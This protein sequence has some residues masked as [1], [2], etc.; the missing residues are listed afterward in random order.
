MV[1]MN[2]TTGSLM[3]IHLY[4]GCFYGY[5]RLMSPNSRVGSGEFLLIR[6]S[7]V[8]LLANFFWKKKNCDQIKLKYLFKI[9]AGVRVLTWFI[10]I[11]VPDEIR[12]ILSATG[13]RMEKFKALILELKL[14][15]FKF[16]LYYFLAEWFWLSCQDFYTSNSSSINWAYVFHTLQNNDSFICF[17][18]IT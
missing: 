15:G 8:E 9:W 17:L 1:T 16:R 6:R 5:V 10:V 13:S 11:F 18:M 7:N 14:S 2:K 4:S 12:M 3:H